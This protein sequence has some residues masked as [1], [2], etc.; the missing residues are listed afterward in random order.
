[1]TADTA[2]KNRG[3]PGRGSGV[4]RRIGYLIIGTS[5]D[6]LGKLHGN[7]R[8][9]DPGTGESSPPPKGGQPIRVQAVREAVG[10]D[11]CRHMDGRQTAV[12]SS[13]AAEF[14]APYKLVIERTGCEESRR[15]TASFSN[16]AKTAEIRL[17]ACPLRKD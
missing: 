5:A 13:R 17:P 2:G 3:K 7:S 11:A 16:R 9:W 4:L 12:S 10:P 6:P 15:R 1:M 8:T 14:N